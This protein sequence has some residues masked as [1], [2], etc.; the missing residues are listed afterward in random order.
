MSRPL[1]PRIVA[2]KGCQTNIL[3]SDS[4]QRELSPQKQPNFSPQVP[5]R[6]RE[7][8]PSVTSRLMSHER[9]YINWFT[10]ANET[11]EIPLLL[12]SF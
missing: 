1:R 6:G 8:R 11:F 12:E 5:T 9:C 10:V 4:S 7:A 3:L 2:L